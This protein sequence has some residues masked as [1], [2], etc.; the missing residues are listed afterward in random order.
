[1]SG[2]LSRVGSFAWCGTQ[3]AGPVEGAKDDA[4]RG[5]AE[6]RSLGRAP[7]SH[8]AAPLSGRTAALPEPLRGLRGAASLGGRVLRG[9]R[10]QGGRVLRGAHERSHVPRPWVMTTRSEPR[11]FF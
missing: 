6:V 3:D 2:I 10:P 7:S 5:L 11:F 4:V 8:S 1:V 9:P